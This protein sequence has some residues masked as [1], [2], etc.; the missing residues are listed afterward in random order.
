MSSSASSVI[1]I[2]SAFAQSRGGLAPGGL[3]AGLA[4]ALAAEDCVATPITRVGDDEAGRSLMAAIAAAGLPL[5]TIQIDRDLPTARLREG[6]LG[7]DGSGRLDATA[8]F[9]LL[10]W[11]GE[12]S[13]LAANC[14]WVLFD[15][16]GRRHAQSRG[17]IDRF[18]YEA[19]SAVR[20]FD[21]T[22]RA[23]GRIERSGALGGLEHAQVALLDSPALAEF[24]GSDLDPPRQLAV[25]RDRWELEVALAIDPSAPLRLA[26]AGGETLAGSRSTHDA[27]LLKARVLAAVIA[28]AS[29][30]ELLHRC[31]APR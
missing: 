29:P 18:L 10:Q 24:G 15:A 1:L 23:P 4:I 2:G 25:V 17:V 31:E 26:L 19:R 20:I 12:L 11:D 16:L 7:G 9:D 27:A 13:G 21:L 3:A 6:L 28:G 22:L 30:A 14:N 8:A 5:S